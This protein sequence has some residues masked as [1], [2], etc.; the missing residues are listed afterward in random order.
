MLL[1]DILSETRLIVEGLEAIFK[2]DAVVMHFLT[3]YPLHEEIWNAF[4]LSGIISY[5]SAGY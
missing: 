3:V 4:P 5:L 1:L 2:D